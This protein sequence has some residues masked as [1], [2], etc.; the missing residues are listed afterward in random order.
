MYA[1]LK[2]AAYL[3]LSIP[4]KRYTFDIVRQETSF[5]TLLRNF[6]EQAKKPSVYEI[7]DALYYYRSVKAVDVWEDDYKD[8][9]EKKRFSVARALELAKEYAQKPYFDVHCHVFT[10][11]SFEETLNM[12]IETHLVK[13]DIVEIIEPINMSNEFN[14]V[15]KRSE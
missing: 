5:V 14:V 12:L 3:F 4:D 11:T 15:L 1:I 6:Q 10:S 2:P 8:K 9:L 13:F 7:F